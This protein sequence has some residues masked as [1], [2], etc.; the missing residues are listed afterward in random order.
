M[1]VH[2]HGNGNG[3]QHVKVRLD[4]TRLIPAPQFGDTEADRQDNQRRNVLF[5][6][7][8]RAD[9]ITRLAALIHEVDGEH[10]LGAAA[11]A[12]ALIARG[13]IVRH[14]ESSGRN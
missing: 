12:E 14:E 5:H 9:D 10:R 11:L 8:N 2:E 7:E 3:P 1:K 4:D 13:V 6:N